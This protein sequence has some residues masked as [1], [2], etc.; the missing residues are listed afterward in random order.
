MVV[1]MDK[2]ELYWLVVDDEDDNAT[3]KEDIPIFRTPSQV[4]QA[5][6]R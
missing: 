6:R 5:A 3:T 2:G 4:F 1:A